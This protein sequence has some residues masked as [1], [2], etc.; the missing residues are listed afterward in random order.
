M[1]NLNQI[2]Q[3]SVFI[4]KTLMIIFHITDK[5]WWKTFEGL[6]YYESPTLSEEKF[7]HLST[8]S[9]VSGVLERYYQGKTDLLKL[10]IDSEKLISEL[11]FEKATNDE[12]FPHLFGKLN[13][14]A[15]IK[16]E[17]I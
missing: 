11:K 9:Q 16:I 12:F 7:I 3:L 17:E 8:E 10:Y 1:K 4:E 15:I 6:D 13:K 5:N 2:N 14:S